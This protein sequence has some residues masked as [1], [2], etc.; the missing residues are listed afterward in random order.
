MWFFDPCFSSDLIFNL[1]VE[2]NPNPT[3]NGA[4]PSIL[5]DNKGKESKSVQEKG[6]CKGNTY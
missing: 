6:D 3:P 2:G 1:S 4:G 5:D